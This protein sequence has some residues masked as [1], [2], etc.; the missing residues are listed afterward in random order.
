MFSSGELVVIFI[1][2]FLV[3]GPKRLPELGRALGKV[4]RELNKAMHDVKDQMDTDYEKTEKETINETAK[5]P[6]EG[7]ITE[8]KPESE[9]KGKV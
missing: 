5:A 9:G 3:F 1:V 2:A 6:V 7:D 4:L 8:D